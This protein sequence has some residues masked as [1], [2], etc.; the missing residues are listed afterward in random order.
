MENLEDAIVLVLHGMVPLLEGF[1]SALP[2]HC[3]E[4][5][6]QSSRFRMP[7]GLVSFICADFEKYF[8]SSL[9]AQGSLQVQ[10]YSAL[11]LFDTPTKAEFSTT[12]QNNLLEL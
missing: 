3:P 5:Q 1:T 10:Q 9:L 8:D 12:T 7:W 6:N 2:R 4:I 11:L